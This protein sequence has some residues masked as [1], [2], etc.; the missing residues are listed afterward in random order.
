MTDRLKETARDAIV[1]G[2]LEAAKSPEYHVADSQYRAMM[3]PEWCFRTIGEAEQKGFK[4][5]N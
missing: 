2:A 4:P 3:S 1:K 5:A